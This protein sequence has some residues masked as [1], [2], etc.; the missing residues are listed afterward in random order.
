MQRQRDPQEEAARSMFRPQ[1]DPDKYSYIVTNKKGVETTMMEMERILS[2]RQDP[3]AGISTPEI[4]VKRKQAL[5]DNGMP[6]QKDSI[7]GCAEGCLVR[8]DSIYTCRL[9]KARI[10]DKHAIHVNES[11]NYC[12]KKGFCRFAGRTHR[13]LWLFYRMAKWC[14]TSVLGM[15]TEEDYD[16]QPEAELFPPKYEDIDL[17]A[18]EG[19]RDV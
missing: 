13:F 15:D 3:D 5:D 2:W 1:Q 17:I 8:V 19:E 11:V 12:K 14:F 7:A 16:Y 6:F 18:E 10:C 9:C 4:I